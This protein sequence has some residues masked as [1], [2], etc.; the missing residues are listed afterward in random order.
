MS[1]FWSWY[2]RNVN[3]YH[4]NGSYFTYNVW[5]L[6]LSI[7]VRR[8]FASGFCDNSSVE[9]KG[10]TSILCLSVN[11]KRGC[12]KITFQ[13]IT[14]TLSDLKFSDTQSFGSRYRWSL[15]RDD[16]KRTAE[17]GVLLILIRLE[18]QTYSRESRGGKFNATISN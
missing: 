11:S 17:F 14:C 2:H 12:A 8:C 1:L 5:Q 10:F 15:R 13:G 6:L 4:L 3:H 18:I 16:D 9:K 7:P